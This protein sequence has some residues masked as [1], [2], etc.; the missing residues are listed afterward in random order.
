MP[1][2]PGIRPRQS[3]ARRLDIAARRGFPTATTILLLLACGA[4]LGLPGRAELQIGMGL[5]CVF[6]WSVFRPGSMPPPAVFLIGLLIDLLGFGPLGVNAVVL[7]ACHGAA[8]RW[9]RD[10]AR[11][12]FLLTWLVFAV[13]GAAAAAVGW[14]LVCVLAFRIYPVAPAALQ[15]A[16]CVGL[17]PAIAVMLGRAHQTLAEPE[18]A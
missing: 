8:L 11:G 10:L 7:L 12:G 13:V 3:L 14:A 16:L 6:F 4:P 5:C 2:H 9:R 15:A 17:Y 1:S 18:H